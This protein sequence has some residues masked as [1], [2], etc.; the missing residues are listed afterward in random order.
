MDVL[1]NWQCLE[2]VPYLEWSPPPFPST[3]NKDLSRSTL[4]VIK[5]LLYQ[6]VIFW[7]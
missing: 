2:M 1:V 6:K 5:E 3:P 4:H 7:M